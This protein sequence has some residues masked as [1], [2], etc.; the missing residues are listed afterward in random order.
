MKKVILTIIF[1]ASTMVSMAQ[2]TKIAVG[3]YGA[4][5][6]ELTYVNE[7]TALN[8]GAYGGVLL[9]H[10]WLIGLSGNNISFKHNEAGAD[11]KMQLNYYGL[12]TEYRFMPE[13][14]VNLS[15]GVTGALGWLERENFDS[16]GGMDKD[17]DYT[18]VIQPKVG[19]NIKVFQFMQV[20]AYGSYRF[21]GNTNST[22]QTG[23]NLNGAGAGIGLVFGS[24]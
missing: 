23:K 18:S 14:K 19:L 17:G 16:E 10:K 15:L 6:A 2:S 21:T 22:F 1:S 8:L 9:N 5:T 20:Q 11:R 3:G 12:Y 24:F 13:R 4:G 7:K